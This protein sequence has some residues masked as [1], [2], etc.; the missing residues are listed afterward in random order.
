VTWIIDAGPMQKV[1]ATIQQALPAFSPLFAPWRLTETAAGHMPNSFALSPPGS[2]LH[3]M[4][5]QQFFFFMD[6]FCSK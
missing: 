2:I 4:N 6:H 5:S 3:F 1:P